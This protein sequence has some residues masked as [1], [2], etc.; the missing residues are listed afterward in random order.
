MEG[1]NCRRRCSVLF[2]LPRVGIHTGL[3]AMLGDIERLAVEIGRD[4]GAVRLFIRRLCSATLEAATPL[5]G[6]LVRRGIDSRTPP[7][8][9][10]KPTS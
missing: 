6:V 7:L 8:K 5:L 3:P 4:A 10:H 1:V 9:G 2:G